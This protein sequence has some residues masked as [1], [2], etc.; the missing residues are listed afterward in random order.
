LSHRF[1]TI[2]IRTASVATSACINLFR[3]DLMILNAT[4]I[5]LKV[6]IFVWIENA[7]FIGIRE[8]EAEEG[9]SPHIQ[10]FQI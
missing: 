4:E 8:A 1:P 9:L 5:K 3:D 2:E 7:T 6:A 10:L